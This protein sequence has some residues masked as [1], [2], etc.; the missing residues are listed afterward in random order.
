M[1][2]LIPPSFLCPC[3][4]PC[5]PPIQLITEQAYLPLPR[6]AEIEGK[7]ASTESEIQ[8][9]WKNNAYTLHFYFSKV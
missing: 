1:V 8:I 6:G 3:P 5:G 4:C 2:L 7:C 9:S